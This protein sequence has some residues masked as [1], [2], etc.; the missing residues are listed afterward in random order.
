MTL[1]FRSVSKEL[2]CR[3]MDLSVHDILRLKDEFDHPEFLNYNPLTLAVSK[4]I[5]HQPS[6]VVIRNLDDLPYGKMMTLV[7][8]YLNKIPFR[9]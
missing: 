2:G 8:L 9:A 4:A 3:M 7:S 5:A 6:I 1:L